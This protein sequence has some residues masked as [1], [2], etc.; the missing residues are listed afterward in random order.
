[1]VPVCLSELQS[2]GSA[3]ITGSFISI[4][5][6]NFNGYFSNSAGITLTSGRNSMNGKSE[7][8]L[9]ATLRNSHR[10]C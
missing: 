6:V 7:I 5:P 2:I 9:F 10:T 3:R 8:Q 4:N 1:M